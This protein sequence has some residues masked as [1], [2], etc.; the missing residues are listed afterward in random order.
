MSEKYSKSIFIF[1]RDLRIPDNIGLIQALKSSDRVIPIFILTPEQLKLNPYKSNNAVQF[2]MESLEELDSQLKKAKSRLFYFYG[3]PDIVLK[4]ILERHEDIEAVYVNADYTPYSIKR[5]KALKQVCDRL[6][7]EFHSTEDLLLNPVGSITTGGGK[8]YSKFTPYYNQAKKKSVPKPQTST[9]KNFISS[10]SGPKG[11]YTG[12]PKSFYKHNPHL[13]RKGGRSNGLKIL[14][15][16]KPFKKY[17]SMRNCLNY[18]TTELS[19]YLK[20]GCI[21]IREAYHSFN[22]KLGTRNDL[23]KQLYWR[24]F[25]HNITYGFPH[26][27]GGPMKK[28]Y[29]KLK[30][31]N[32]PTH[33][34]RWKEGNTGFPIV[35]AAMRSMNK[36]GFMHNRARMIVSSFLIKILLTDWRKGEK[37]FAQTLMDYDVHNNNGGWQWSASTGADSQPYFRIFNP[38]L[39]G[40]KFD[41]KATYIKKWIPELADVPA[42]HIHQWDKFHKEH[43]VK[44]PEPIVDYAK[45]KEES[46]KRYKKV[47]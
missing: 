23:I 42:K 41:P 31:D 34:K 4:K 30:W 6:E 44:Y 22:S 19:A 11:T 14:A 10:S 45:N 8:I 27:I 36:T 7:V 9:P 24:D 33:F 3:K 38:W 32:N 1:R 40:E 43:K 25:Y 18:R 5:D 12:S 46:I 26:V 29:S 21:S 35:D 47:T 17:N 16:L 15:S 2:M 28:Q 39:Q 37:Y 20:F 13:I